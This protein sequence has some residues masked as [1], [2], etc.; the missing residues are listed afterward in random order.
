MLTRTDCNRTSS[1]SLFV[2]ASI[3]EDGNPYNKP[4]CPQGHIQSLNQVVCNEFCPA[5]SVGECSGDHPP[6]KN[7][8]KKS[9]LCRLT[10]PMNSYGDWQRN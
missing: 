3:K 4:W 8:I 6:Y 9:M 7:C 10:W 1:E 5:Y 2:P